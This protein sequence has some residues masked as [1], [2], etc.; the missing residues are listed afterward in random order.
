[1]RRRERKGKGKGKSRRSHRARN[2][3]HSADPATSSP[4]RN[5][6]YMR[7]SDAVVYGR[8]RSP[9]TDAARE[10]LD[11]ELTSTLSGLRG[12]LNEARRHRNEAPL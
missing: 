11:Y 2:R 10:H 9:Y 5:L 7:A 12:T 4:P 8:P 1:M 3:P 6:D